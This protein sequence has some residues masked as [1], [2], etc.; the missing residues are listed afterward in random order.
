MIQFLNNIWS[1]LSNENVELINI[2]LVPLGII[3]NY[4]MMNLFL[5]IFNVKAD[6][7]QKV[8]YVSLILSISL[9]TTNLI[10]SPFNIVLN[11]ACT[12]FLIKF[13]FKLNIFK[14]FISL[15][16]PTF[17][18]ALLNILLQNPYLT[19]LD[20]SFD[21]FVVTPIYRFTYLIILY[22]LI[23][24]ITI[25]VKKSMNMKFGLD[26]LDAL[27]HKTRKILCLNILIGFITLSIQLIIT[28]FYI[29]IV[30]I[31]ITILSFV[32]LISFFALSIYSFT[33]IIKLATTKRELHNAEEYN[34]S[35]EI[36]Y[37]KV[38]GFKHDFDN[39]V[40]TIDGF[41]ENDDMPGLKDYFNEVKKDC[42]IT[43]NISLINPRTINNPGIYSLLNNKYF[44]AT[45]LGITFD[46]EYFLDLNN[47]HVNLYELSRILGI[48]I[49]NAIEEAEKCKNKIVK[50]SFLREERNS[51]TVITI[52]NTYSNKDVD[53]KKIFDKGE[54]GKANHSGIGL[55]EVRNYIKKGKN[56][57]L[58][59]SKNDKFFKQ[60]LSI[61]DI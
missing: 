31:F 26:M 10:P 14:S 16:V 34:H 52:Q 36:L 27:D 56:L 29:D 28:E 57:D 39:I 4:I 18:F 33:R 6:K 46:I 61:Y 35:L 60:E 5:T 24:L 55:W 30:P 37:D 1:S 11:Y 59:T 3:E 43:N 40:S 17:I 32:L 7:K 51:R 48:L 49:D 9:L 13:I 21:Y 19:I 41:I 2:L 44:K 8:L 20:I 47:I 22:S 25:L 38:K 23:L 12:I 42:Q 58:F 45:N 15:I 54:S 53:I 50:L